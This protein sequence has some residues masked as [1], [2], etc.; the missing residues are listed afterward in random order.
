MKSEA[1]KLVLILIVWFL[2]STGFCG[3]PVEDAVFA[4]DFDSICGNTIYSVVGPNA[5]K[6]SNILRASEE[7][8]FVDSLQHLLVPDGQ[9]HPTVMTNTVLDTEVSEL[10][11]T[12]AYNDQG[13]NGSEA[14]GFNLV[15]LLSN[16]RG[17]GPVLE[18]EIVLS[19]IS[20]PDR[21]LVFI[22]G[23]E[24]VVATAKLPFQD[25]IWHQIAV[26]FNQGAVTFYLDGQQLGD[27]LSANATTIIAQTNDWTLIEDPVNQSTVDE[28]FD[29]GLYD[30]A[31]LWYRALTAS[32]I[33]SI[34]NDGISVNIGLLG[35]INLDDEINLLDVQP[36]VELLSS[37]ECLREADI[38][39][40]GTVDLLDVAP[41][42]S[43]LAGG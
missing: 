32:E 33:A 5:T 17:T 23:G 3:D 39:Q 25:S 27:V 7:P 20:N 2:T 26:V 9:T 35:D 10:T 18:T 6:T 34:H 13:D 22:V 36:F 37:N 41:F 40:D 12:I 19:L 4:H 11:F 31:A 1:D 8:L 24:G 21:Q 16:Y 29:D 28:Y 15:R 43:L 42:V 14:G 38:N 30:N